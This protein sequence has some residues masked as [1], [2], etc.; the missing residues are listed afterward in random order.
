MNQD[1]YPKTPE[2]QKQWV[3]ESLADRLAALKAKFETAKKGSK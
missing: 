2:A 3:E 1:I